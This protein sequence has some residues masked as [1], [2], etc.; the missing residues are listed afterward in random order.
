MQRRFGTN[1]RLNDANHVI[2]YIGVVI[3]SILFY[4][5]FVMN[6]KFDMSNKQT[7]Q[8]FESLLSTIK[9]MRIETKIDNEERDKNLKIY[10]EERDKNLKIYIEERVDKLNSSLKNHIDSSIK[11]LYEKI[12]KSHH[13]TTA[14]QAVVLLS[15]STSKNCKIN[16]IEYFSTEHAITYRDYLFSVGVKHSPC[17]SQ[18]SQGTYSECSDIDV[19]IR[20]GCPNTTKAIDTSTYLNLSTG[21]AASTLGFVHNQSRFWTGT[22]AGR[23]GISVNLSVT[24][25]SFI[26][27]NSNEYLFE[28]VSQIE[29]M[30][31]G[32]TIN[33]H[34]YTGCVHGSR[35]DWKSDGQRIGLNMAVVIPATAIFQCI[36]GIIN[37][38]LRNSSTYDLPLMKLDSK[39]CRTQK[40]NVPHF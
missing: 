34:G 25:T 1:F 35:S 38:D 5:I 9:E 24:N 4:Q 8:R 2:S 39:I 13:D 16:D 15:A 30:S 26:P 6:Q 3:F 28:G 22:L 17:W 23:L 32:A 29:G 18:E 12:Q 20:R 31:G 37:R 21:H 10:I 27:F 11:I 40:V 14:D 36:D 19:V 7:N 33:G